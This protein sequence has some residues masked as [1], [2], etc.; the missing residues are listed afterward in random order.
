MKTPFCVSLVLLI[1]YN[2]IR[3]LFQA[4]HPREFAQTEPALSQVKRPMLAFHHGLYPP[5]VV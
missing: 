1:G 2:S 3:L 4:I 5:C